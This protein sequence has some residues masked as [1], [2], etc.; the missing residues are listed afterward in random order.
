[1]RTLRIFH[2]RRW[3]FS[4][5]VAFVLG[6]LSAEG[7]ES[8]GRIVEFQKGVCYAH[9]WRSDV[10]Y[11]SEAS[12]R[13]LSRLREAG[14][15]WISITPFAY[16][17]RLGDTT[18]RTVYDRRRGE[19]DAAMR[20]QVEQAHRRG[21]K[22][23]LKPHIW[24]SGGAW[25][26]EISFDQEEQWEVWFASYSEMISHYAELA[27]SS[28]MDFFCIGNELKAATLAQPDRWRSLIARVR[29][30]Y[31]GPLIYAANWDEY[32]RLPWWGDLDAIGI[33]AYFPLSSYENPTVD[34]LCEGAEAVRDR[35]ARVQARFD[36]PVI[37][38]EIGYRSIA[39]AAARPWEYRSS[40][41]SDLELQGRCYEAIF[42]TFWD[43]SWFRGVYW[44]KWMS[45]APG[46][47]AAFDR[48]PYSPRNKP[49][50]AVLQEWYAKPRTRP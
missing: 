49:A 37:F 7:A 35:I 27:Q 20:V 13:S 25:P 22:V 34:Q 14:V 18:L 41:P 47:E 42:R 46:G 16:Q 6:S 4:A 24:I 45:G 17:S 21:L 2:C 44:W 33:N 28:G 40:G 23:M 19:S 36:R 50:E 29:G 48:D 39:G 31:R 32:A 9:T 43:V 3:A 26:G 5:T 38:T 15:E 10:G 12:A 11:G 1:M 30:L 8:A